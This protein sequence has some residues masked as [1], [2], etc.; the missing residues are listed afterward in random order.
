[1]LSAHDAG[2]VSTQEPAGAICAVI[3]QNSSKGREDLTLVIM[4]QQQQNTASVGRCYC[5]R[6]KSEHGS[7]PSATCS[8]ESGQLISVKQMPITVNQAETLPA[9]PPEQEEER[10]TDRH[11]MSFEERMKKD[12]QRPGFKWFMYTLITQNTEKRA[13][14]EKEERRRR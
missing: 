3:P 14:A 10:K 2:S 5:T 1:M 8:D 9:T 4:L 6:R 13:L 12:S 7:L 11:I